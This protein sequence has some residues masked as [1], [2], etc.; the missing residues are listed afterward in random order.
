MTP[1]QW[2]GPMC[3]LAPNQLVYA[4]TSPPM[5]QL[6]LSNETP[7]N[8]ASVSHWVYPRAPLNIACPQPHVQP[9]P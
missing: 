2:W 3:P 1:H 4:Q 8:V 6:A 9:P 5:C 7:T